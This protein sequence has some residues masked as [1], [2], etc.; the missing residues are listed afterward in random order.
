ML[1][2][3]LLAWLRHH[4]MVQYCKAI[5][6]ALKWRHRLWQGSSEVK[7]RV[8]KQVCCSMDSG[9]GC[10]SMYS[11]TYIIFAEDTH[12][13][14]NTLFVTQFTLT[15]KCT[16]W[17][18]Q[19]AVITWQNDVVFSTWNKTHLF[20]YLQDSTSTVD[21]QCMHNAWVQHIAGF[22]IP[23]ELVPPKQWWTPDHLVLN[24]KA[25]PR[26]ALYAW[27]CSICMC[28]LCKEIVGLGM[29]GQGHCNRVMHYLQLEETEHVLGRECK[30]GS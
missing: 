2:W 8:T 19:M 4:K 23:K 26:N 22:L 3:P 16:S 24:V 14:Y 6:L 29:S 5:C 20:T 30:E 27:L 17:F 28:S 11:C 9:I 21:F 10:L 25:C 18:N 12:A 1:L 7:C 15:S 13:T